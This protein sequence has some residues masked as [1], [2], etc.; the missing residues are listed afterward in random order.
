MAKKK[1]TKPSPAGGRIAPGKPSRWGGPYSDEVRLRAVQEIV[2]H[3]ATMATVSRTLGVPVSTLQVWVRS[4]REQGE[5]GLRERVRKLGRPY[6]SERA[7]KREAVVEVREAHPEYG[8]RRIRDVLARFEALGISESVVRRVLHEAGLLETR[9]PTEEREHPVRRFER[10]EPNQLWQSDIFTFLL[11]RHE[12]LYLTAFMDDHSRFIVSYALAHHQRSE[13]VMEALR[14]GIA[15]YGTPR[16]ILTDQG[17]QYTAWRGE[18]DFELELRRE[19][20]RHIK[21]RP[22]H[23]QTLGKIERFWKTLWEEF[24]SRTVFADFA[25]CERRIRL[26][27]DAYNFQRPHQGIESLVPADRFFRAAA[28]VRESIEK[29]VA[30]NAMRLAH[31]RPTQKPFYLVGRL[32]DRNLSIAAAGRGLQVRVGD[33]EPTTIELGNKEAD[34][35]QNT[36]ARWGNETTAKAHG[37]QAAVAARAEGPRR[38][39]AAT[40]PDDPE[41]AERRVVGGRGS[42]ARGDHAAALLP[43]R[44]TW[45]AG[46]AHSALA[47]DARGRHGGAS[48]EAAAGAGGRAREDEAPARAASFPDEIDGEAWRDD[49]G[50][51]EAPGPELDEAWLERFDETEEGEAWET[52]ELDPDDGW[53]DRVL[54]WERKLTSCDARAD[55]DELHAGTRGASGGARALPSDVGGAERDDDGV[56]GGAAARHVAQSLPDLASPWSGGAPRWHFAWSAGTPGEAGARGEP[57]AGVGAAEEAERVAGGATRDDGPTDGGRSGDGAR[58][59]ASAESDDPGE[60]D[61]EPGEEG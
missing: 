50:D 49:A 48:A 5:A 54:D 20:I 58:L 59:G 28:H 27:I 30:A 10:A 52:R 29:S 47:R 55:E 57:R 31:E 12:R 42:G 11:R 45:A 61:D 26:F 17:R 23:P 37:A 33:E 14:R 16:E 1:E 13:L 4:Y 25:D 40:V 6:S 21:S 22:Q 24:L 44:E 2:D 3:G 56:R 51:E 15:A 34:D 46:D 19:G 39:G 41:R 7:A 32:G 9:P 35:G 43:A 38:D 36:V 8:T 53:R 60:E 18:T